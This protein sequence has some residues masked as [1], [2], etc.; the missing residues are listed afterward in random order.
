[1]LTV[2]TSPW[3][4]HV[5][6]SCWP[7]RQTGCATATVEIAGNAPVGATVNSA[8]SAITELFTED[9]MRTTYWPGVRP[10][11]TSTSCMASRLMLCTDSILASSSLTP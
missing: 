3:L 5:I 10:S 2:G 8:L 1:M 9:S 11:G 6:T 4:L 7:V